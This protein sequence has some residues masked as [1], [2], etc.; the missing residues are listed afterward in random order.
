[1]TAF[2]AFSTR[3]LSDYTACETEQITVAEHCSCFRQ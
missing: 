2:I 3:K 1:M